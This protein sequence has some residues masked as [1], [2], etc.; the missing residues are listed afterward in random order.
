MTRSALWTWEAGTRPPDPDALQRMYAAVAEA[1]APTVASES[2]A[3]TGRRV[4]MTQLRLLAGW[5]K[6]EVAR[7]L[8][9]TRSAA[10]AWEAGIRRLA[11]GKLQRMYS[12]VAAALT[13]RR[14]R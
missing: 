8:G 1:W 10:S 11:P 2:P 6:A 5:T 14:A 3:D 13:Q 12:E 7:R 9:V 4:A